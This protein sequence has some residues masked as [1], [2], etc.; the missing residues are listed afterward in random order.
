MIWIPISKQMLWKMEQLLN[1]CIILYIVLL[2]K[3]NIIIVKIIL[4]L[5]WSVVAVYHSLASGAESDLPNCGLPA[6]FSVH[7]ASSTLTLVGSVHKSR[8]DNVVRLWV[9]LR[10][11]CVLCVLQRGHSCGGCDLA[12]LCVTMI[13]RSVIYLYWVGQGCDEWDGNVSLQSW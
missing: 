9:K 1:G 12:R 13:W 6:S 3:E 8:G 5:H 11:W 4:F 7:L 10:R 2:F